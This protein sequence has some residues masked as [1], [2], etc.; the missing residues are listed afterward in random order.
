MSTVLFGRSF[1]LPAAVSTRSRRFA[2][3]VGATSLAFLT[4]LAAGQATTTPETPATQIA[5]AA[6]T[7]SGLSTKSSIVDLAD[8]AWKEARAGQN[9][10]LIETLG[11]APPAG[12]TPGLTQFRSNV[13]SLNKNLAKREETRQKKASEATEKMEKAL[14]KNTPDGLSD[15]LRYSVELYLLSTDKD[16]YKRDPKTLSLIERASAAAKEAEAKGDWFTANEL[17]YRLNGLL[18]EEG[19][20]RNDLKRLGQRLMMLRMYAPE[21]FWKL[22]NSERIKENKTPLPPYNGLGEDYREK[23]SKVSRPMVARAIYAAV[24]Q[25]I[26]KPAMSKLILGGLDS[27]R[28]LIT[29]NDLQ[30]VF[31]GLGNAVARDAMLAM[32]DQKAARFA[33][34][35]TPV[36]MD[37]V[38]N[39][40]DELVQTSKS[41]IALPEN[42]VLHEFG[43][44]VMGKL[45]DFSAIIWPDEV[46]RFDR[47]TQGNFRGVG[48]QIQMD[49]ES[50]LIKVVTPIEGSPA[51]RA[52]IRTGDFIKK[53]NGQSAVGINLNQA[54]DLITG[55]VDSHVNVTMERPDG[56]DAD[57]KALSKELDF[58]LVRAVIPIHSVKGWRRVGVREDDWDWFVDRPNQI[59]YIRLTQFTEDTTTDLRAAIQRMR[60]DGGLNGLIVDL[61]FNPGGLLTEAVSV[62]NTFIDAGVIVSTNGTVPGERKSATPG[63]ALT[64]DVP[65]VFLIN[66]GSASASEIVSGA[67]R[68]YSDKG[69]ISAA[70]IGQRS[71]G[72]GSVQNVWSIADNGEAKMKLTTQ[73]YY[74]PD[75]RRLHRTPGSSNWGVDPHLKVEDLVEN[76]SDAQKLRMDADVIPIDEH[77]KMVE[78][79]TPRPDPQKLL[80]DGIDLQLQ[81]ALAILQAKAS[82]KGAA[83]HVRLAQ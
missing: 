57:G 46:A 62:S 13:D 43:N 58:D 37:D 15:A 19:N 21:E 41:T 71:F 76:T 51:Q 73:Y 56:S 8:Q 40:I 26:D 12:L 2:A 44:G 70:I 60:K 4:S 80:D 52:G 65:V 69:D 66:E 83:E 74:L 79:K 48:I 72:K 31:N 24:K 3:C 63:Y 78:S 34:S 20:Y 77:G 16:G 18:E 33:N 81:H 54:V 75:N 14:A 36:V 55:E 49:D 28:T 59:G 25:Q 30:R 17:F 45:D 53:I 47:M 32:L 61:R 6:G 39:L 50:Q 82:A 22:R 29:T 7:P 10:E 68:H 38:T 42:V 64:K 35:Q 67:I 11:D 1:A 5:T 9:K 27:V 23:L